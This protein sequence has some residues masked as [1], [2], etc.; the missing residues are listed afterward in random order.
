MKYRSVYK[1]KSNPSSDPHSKVT[2]GEFGICNTGWLWYATRDAFHKAWELNYH[3][4]TF[5]YMNA[6]QSCLKS[7]IHNAEDS[8]ELKEKSYIAFLNF[9]LPHKHICRLT[10]AP[11]WFE[12]G[13]NSLRF[14]L[15]TLLVRAATRYRKGMD[16]R[17]TLF[18]Y[19]PA[20]ETKQAI[21]Y[22]FAG[23]HIYRGYKNEWCDQFFQTKLPLDKLLRRSR[24][25]QLK[26]WFKKR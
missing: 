10:P 4:H 6:L 16:W 9:D 8:L 2:V 26:Q 24:M 1:P 23:H 21:A 14:S 5:Y 20:Y 12:E 19:A 22:F 18:E 25:A 11:F 7:F 3:T 13:F 15:Y 17:E